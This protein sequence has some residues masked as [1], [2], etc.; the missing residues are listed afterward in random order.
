MKITYEDL[1]EIANN[2]EV[3]LL[4]NFNPSHGYYTHTIPV[5]TAKKIKKFYG[6]MPTMKD[7]GKIIGTKVCT[8]FL[9]AWEDSY[10]YIELTS[11]QTFNSSFIK[12]CGHTVYH[13]ERPTDDIGYKLYK[14]YYD[15]F[16]LYDNKEEAEAALE[17]AIKSLVKEARLARRKYIQEQIKAK[18]A[19]INKLN[20]ELSEIGK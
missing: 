13:L 4:K 6:F 2:R 11:S 9:Y 5:E 19:E 7:N 10:T 8:F 15:N 18:Q 20:K 3:I 17:E 14:E 1:K 16:Q 12:Y